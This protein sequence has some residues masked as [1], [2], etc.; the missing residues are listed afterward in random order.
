MEDE[1]V[2][3]VDPE[4]GGAL[5]EGVEGFVVAVVADPHLGLDEDVGPV[6]V[7]SPDGF[8]DLALVAVASSV[9]EVPLG[10]AGR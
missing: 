2:D 4:L 10:P 8:A 1:Q 7:G 3:L 6:D 5:V 9:A